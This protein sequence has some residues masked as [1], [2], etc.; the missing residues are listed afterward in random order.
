MRAPTRFYGP[1]LVATGPATVYTVPATSLG[2][3]R[4]IH[5]ANTT[6]GAVTF[7]LSIGS[8]AAGTRLFPAYSIAAGAILD[9]WCYYPAAAAEIVQVG[10]GTNN[11]LTLTISGDL[12]TLG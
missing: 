4:H 8:D 12:I 11:I 9:H 3:L 10:A 6:A 7:T 5:I 1:A 2:V